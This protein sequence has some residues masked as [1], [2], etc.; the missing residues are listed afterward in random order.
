[1]NPLPDDYYL[2]DQENL[3]HDSD[4]GITQP[5]GPN[6]SHETAAENS[7][8]ETDSSFGPPVNAAFLRRQNIPAQE[9]IATARHDI[10][11]E[12]DR[13]GVVRPADSEEL[14]EEES[15]ALLLPFSVKSLLH[16]PPWVRAE[17]AG[18]SP[19]SPW[20]ETCDISPSRRPPPARHPRHH[21]QVTVSTR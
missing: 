1:M 13:H 20:R 19:I 8:T 12:E 4:Y 17:E 3:P 11:E 7:T 10:E 14:Y 2:S 6:L 5:R 16:T 15:G 21:P 18:M 9:P